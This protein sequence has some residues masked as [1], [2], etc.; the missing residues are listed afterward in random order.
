[1][2]QIGLSYSGEVIKN[3]QRGGGTKH[4]LHIHIMSFDVLSFLSFLYI[5]RFTI[6]FYMLCLSTLAPAKRSVH[7]KNRFHDTGCMLTINIKIYK[8]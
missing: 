2:I 4:N 3:K 1:M 8:G 7:R 5:V 6:V